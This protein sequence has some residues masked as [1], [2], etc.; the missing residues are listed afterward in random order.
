MPLLTTYTDANKIIYENSPHLEKQTIQ[1]TLYTRTVL[2]VKWAWVG[3]DYDTAVTALATV[4]T[5]ETGKYATL[6]RSGDGGAYS[7]EVTEVTEGAWA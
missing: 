6:K 2:T 3:M 1:G 5:P 4:D 7:V